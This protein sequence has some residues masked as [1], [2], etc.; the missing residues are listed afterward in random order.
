LRT[1]GLEFKEDPYMATAPPAIP[2]YLFAEPSDIPAVTVVKLQERPDDFY[3]FAK[4]PDKIPM[5]MT[6]GLGAA[7]WKLGS[8][9]TGDIELEVEVTVGNRTDVPAGLVGVTDAQGLYYSSGT[10]P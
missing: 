7:D 3:L 10:T 1:V 9:L 6:G 2:W 8:F 4:A 5:S